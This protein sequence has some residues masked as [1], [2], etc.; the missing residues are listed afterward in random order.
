LKFWMELGIDGFRLDAV[1][2]LF[3]EEGHNGENHPKTHEYLKRVRKEVDALFPDR[4]LLAEANQWPADVVEYFGDPETGDECQMAFHFPLMPRL[5]MAVRRE[6]RYPI[7]EILANT[8]AIPKNCQWGIFLR[9][10]DELTL[11]MVTDDERDYMYEEYAKDPR[12]KSNV[13][14]A[15]R[16]APLLENDRNQIELFTGLLLS[17][18]GSPVLYYGDEIGM[19]DNIYLGDRDGVRTPMQ[20]N[21]DRN[22]GFSRA[23]PQ[24]LYLPTILDAVYGYQA[25]NVESQMRSTSSLLNW[26]RNMLAVRK[27]HPV[28]GMGSYD[29]LGSSNPSVLAFV[30]EFGDDKVLCVNNLSRFPQ[31]VELDLRRF[32]GCVPT[33]LTGQVRFPRAGDL[34]YLLSLPGHGFMWFGLG[35]AEDT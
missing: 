1:P 24:T 6:S 9:N 27:Q 13:G 3:E 20:W 18:P 29:E 34:P 25:I 5:F 26:T 10:H 22:A 17:L 11:E 21:A 32:K 7:S 8:P 4:V 15:R 14:I 31:P 12:M 16:L 33:E 28:F 35:P 2:Y 19:G 30:R 23:D